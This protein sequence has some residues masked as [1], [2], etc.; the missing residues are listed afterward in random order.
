MKLIRE[1]VEETKLIVEEKLGKGKQYFIE[2]VFLQSQIKNRNG[3]MYPESTMDREVGRYLK[4]SVANNR[5]YGELGHPDT[6]SINLDRVSHLIVDLR[7]E[8]TNWIGKA[9]I[10]E[11]PMGQIARGLLDG[12]ANLGV[13]SRAMG[14][15]KMSNEGINIVQDD[16]M[17]STAADIVADPS[18]PDAFVRGIMENK[19]WIFVDGKFVEQQIEEVR[20]FVKKTSSR[21]L[22]E[23]KIRA[24][25]H[26]LSKIR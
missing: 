8:G 5:A 19:E 10:L 3:R 11:T 4:E 9:K 14:S 13:S 16:F 25:Q 20:S 17:L 24:F 12:G 15:L 2:G 26:F 1:T 23:A 6:P 7:K 21:N 22:E 18:A